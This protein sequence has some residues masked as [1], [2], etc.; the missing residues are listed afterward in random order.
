M[1]DEPRFL[2]DP[3]P[4]PDP[5]RKPPSTAPSPAAPSPAPASVTVPAGWTIMR[6]AGLTVGVPSAWTVRDD[7]GGLSFAVPGDGD[8]GGEVFLHAFGF[9]LRVPEL[10]V[11]V[12]SQR[13]MLRPHQPEIT[14]DRPI[15][16]ETGLPA[17][18]L[19]WSTV[20]PTGER[21]R[22]RAG[23]LRTAAA[24][25]VWKLDQPGAPGA[26]VIRDHDRSFQSLRPR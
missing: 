8:R 16:H 2:K 4:G 23:Y 20:E 5:D 9:E 11:F 18:L 25:Y 13:A 1:P 6:T 14:D 12:A 3:P 17:H 26:A 21:W 22:F 19:A 24:I 15:D 7:P 10:D